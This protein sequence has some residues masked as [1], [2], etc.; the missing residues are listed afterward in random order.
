M[1]VRTA[2]AALALV[3][4]GIF[5][6]RR[7]LLARLLKLPPP[8]YAVGVQRNIPVPMPDGVQ[9]FTD[10]YFPKVAGDFP[11]I[12]MRT[13]YGWGREAALGSGYPLAEL[14]AQRFAERGCHVIVQRRLLPEGSAERDIRASRRL[15]S[16]ELRCSGGRNRG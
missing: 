6:Y 10:H 12:L 11:T 9:L 4:F 1:K 2:L 8:C 7:S 14:P 5:R 15:T 16:G 13:P 3:G